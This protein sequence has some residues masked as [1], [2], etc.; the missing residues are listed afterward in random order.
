MKTKTNMDVKNM[1]NMCVKKYFKSITYT[2]NYAFEVFLH[3]FENLF[4]N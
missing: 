3:Y 4:F 1:T 2:I